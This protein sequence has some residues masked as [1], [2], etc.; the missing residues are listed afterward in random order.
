MLTR[1]LSSLREVLYQAELRWPDLGGLFGLDKSWPGSF[2]DPALTRR[3]S[4]KLGLLYWLSYA[5]MVSTRTAGALKACWPDK[6][7]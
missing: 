5:G 4:P 1:H 6:G 7:F 3:L 2:L